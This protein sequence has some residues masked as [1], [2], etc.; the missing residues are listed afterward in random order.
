MAHNPDSNLQ[1]K[2]AKTSTAD[3]PKSRF[4]GIRMKIKGLLLH[5]CQTSSVQIK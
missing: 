2:M 5:A 1:K 3:P 4:C